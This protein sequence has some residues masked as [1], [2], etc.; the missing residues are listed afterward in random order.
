MFSLP[1]S[2]ALA[3]AAAVALSAARPPDAV[4][5]TPQRELS[6]D[7]PDQT[8]S[9]YT[10]EAGHYQVEI[11]VVAVGRDGDGAVRSLQACGINLK[12]GLSDDMDLQ[13]L[14]PGLEQLHV[15][16][17]EQAEGVGDL[18]TRLKW[19]LCGNDGGAFALAVMPFVT[20]PTG[21]YGLGAGG[22]EAG[23]IVPFTVPLALPVDLGAM[24]E[25]DLAR[26]ADGQG[27][28]GETFL[29]ATAGRDLMGPLGAFLEVAALLRP[30]GEGR[31]ELALDAGATWALSP[32][33]QLDAGVQ[34]GLND[35]AE[36]RRYFLG[37]SLRR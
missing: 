10:V 21:G 28:H 37:L 11:Q 30:S 26:D 25:V 13:L 15:D 5:S 9:P 32:D 24:V 27:S 23:L 29:T 3:A 35:E 14:F 4:G 17:E 8:E 2:A 36:D 22:M 1:N 7:R 20:W 19:N 33:A 31:T 6:T 16:G 12:R 34:W 18:M